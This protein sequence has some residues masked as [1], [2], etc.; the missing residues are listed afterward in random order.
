MVKARA[1]TP[2]TNSLAP[3]ANF[4][5]STLNIFCSPRLIIFFPPNTSFKRTHVCRD[6]RRSAPSVSLDRDDRT[7]YGRLGAS[8][9]SLLGRDP[10]PFLLR[11]P[12]ASAGDRRTRRFSRGGSRC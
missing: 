5:R 1:D 8:I 9:R 11:Q 2:P 6:V 4:F 3:S 12:T 7:H 10:C